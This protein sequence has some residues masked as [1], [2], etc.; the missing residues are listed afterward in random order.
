M[1]TPN[2]KQ[3]NAKPGGQF[4]KSE[5]AGSKPGFCLDFELWVLDFR[6]EVTP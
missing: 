1:E 4:W 6:A 5:T 3:P 2:A